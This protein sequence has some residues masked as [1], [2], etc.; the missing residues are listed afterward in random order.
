MKPDPFI[1]PP[2]CGGQAVSREYWLVGDTVVRHTHD[3]SSGQSCFHV[4]RRLARDTGEYWNGAPKNRRWR[5]TSK[6]HINSLLHDWGY[7]IRF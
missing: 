3:R 1:T 5:S 2:E 7:D 4:S 6:E